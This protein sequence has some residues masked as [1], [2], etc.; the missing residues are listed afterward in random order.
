MNNKNTHHNERPVA[1][2][3][4]VRLYS[5]PFT[6]AKTYLFAL[7]FVVGNIALPQLC[8][9]LP[10]GGPTLLPIYFFTLIAAYKLGIRAGMMTAIASPLLNHLLFGMPAAAM[11]PV[12]LLKSMLLAGAAAYIA[13]RTR[14]VSLVA[15]LGVVIAYQTIGTLGEWALSGSLYTAMQDFRIAL[16]G[17]LI[18]WLGG[19]ALLK[20]MAGWKLKIEN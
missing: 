14:E 1:V 9:L 5:L 16:P 10:V 4:P 13:H 2:E 6:E 12:I 3:R 17:L 11:L 18:Q 15:L 20:A 8:H 19:C 7:L